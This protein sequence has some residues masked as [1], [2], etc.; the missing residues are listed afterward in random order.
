MLKTQRKFIKHLKHKEKCDINVS[1]VS[2]LVKD[3]FSSKLGNWGKDLSSGISNTE[4]I[5]TYLFSICMLLLWY[6][7]EDNPNY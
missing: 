3:A 6:V 2:N 4:K 7:Y 1:D 5:K